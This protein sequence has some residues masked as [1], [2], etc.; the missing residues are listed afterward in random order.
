MDCL[1]LKREEVIYVGDDPPFDIVGAKNARIKVVW[2]NP[3]NKALPPQYPKPDFE[4]Q[5]IKDLLKIVL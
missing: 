4:I 2:F 3:K 1:G 5:K